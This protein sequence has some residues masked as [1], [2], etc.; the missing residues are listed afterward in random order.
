MTAF[1]SRYAA[2]TFALLAVSG[3]ALAQA[4][5]DRLVAQAAVL[6]ASVDGQLYVGAWTLAKEANPDVLAINVDWG[7][8]SEICLIS[9]P[10][11]LCRTVA[12]GEHYDFVISFDGFDYP[13]RIAGAEPMAVFDAA[14]QA[15]NRGR[16][17]ILVPEVYELVNIAIA[18]TPR[19]QDFGMIYKDSPYYSEVQEHFAAYADHPLITAIQAEISRDQMKYHRLKMNGYSFEFNDDGRIVRSS[20]YDRTGFSGDTSN[21]LAPYQQLLQSFADE[22]G[23]RAFYSAHRPLY[24][25]QISY[26][27]D[28]IDVAGALAWLQ[29]NFPAVKPYDSNKIIF[30]PLVH[31]MQSLTTFSSN[32]FTELQPH[33]NFPYAVAEDESLTPKD[34]ALRRGTILFTEMNHGFIN[35]TALAHASRIGETFADRAFWTTPRQLG[36]DYSDPMSLFNEYMNWALVSVYFYD[37]ADAADRDLMIQRLEPFMEGRGFAQFV[38]FSRFLVKL[39]AE[40][41]PGA[42]MADLY[43]QI[44]DWAVAHYAARTNAD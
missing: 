16:T 27:R 18:L 19:G 35:P 36:N 4:Q 9:G 26:Y 2:L 31:G 10:H 14:Y 42:T 41:A 38:P 7:K 23:F 17:Q 12:A 6:D 13:T 33:V 39:Y 11:S 22:T 5:A 40:R 43:P 37:K 8:S 34:V 15:E 44:V 32:G 28:E 24:D 30:S 3:P 21:D 20:V 1:L 25:S 29:A